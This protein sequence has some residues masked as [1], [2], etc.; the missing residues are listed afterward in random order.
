MIQMG[1][2]QAGYREGEDT[3]EKKTGRI[4]VRNR[5]GEEQG[6][7]R[8]GIKQAGYRTGTAQDKIKKRNRTGQD[9]GQEQN[10]RRLYRTGI[11]K[12]K[13]EKKRQKQNTI[14]DTE[15]KYSRTKGSYWTGLRGQMIQDRKELA[16]LRREEM[17]SCENNKFHKYVCVVA[18]RR[19]MG[20]HRIELYQ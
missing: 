4:Q 19:I 15:R 5:A 6:R 9:T 2:K 16:E 3:E 8:Q 10:R 14:E 11:N 13:N 1:I 17:Y 7:I 20:T 18:C 12:G